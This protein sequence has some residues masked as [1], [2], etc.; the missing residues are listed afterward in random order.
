MGRWVWATRVDLES[1]KKRSLWRDKTTTD[2]ELKKNWCSFLLWRFLF[3]CFFYIFRQTLWLSGFFSSQ[4]ASCDVVRVEYIY[5]NEPFC[6]RCCCAS[7]WRGQKKIYE[8]LHIIVTRVIVL[9]IIISRQRGWER[10]K[11]EREEEFAC[12]LWRW[13]SSM[14][15]MRWWQ[16]ICHW[17][18][19]A[20][21]WMR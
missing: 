11:S 21:C 7:H 9:S 17:P 4:H 3:C 12:G 19:S 14:V 16:F 15:M 20:L 10:R 8:N 5:L 2:S 1:A 18:R 6:V 13:R